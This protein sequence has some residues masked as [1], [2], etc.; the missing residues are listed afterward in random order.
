[1]LGT[2]ISISE[3]ILWTPLLGAL[4]LFL[5]I[6]DEKGAKN[7]AM[8]FSLLS[9][10]ACVGGMY[11]YHQ[12]QHYYDLMSHNAADPHYQDY[13]SKYV[14]YYEI[15]NANWV[16]MPNIGSSFALFMDGMSLL[17]ILLTCISFP[18]IFLSQRNNS[19]SKPV[20]FYALMLLSQTGLIG[21]FLAKDALV[22]YVFWELALIPVYFLASMW[23]GEKRV[24]AAFKFF[25]YTFLGSLLM[26][27]ALI[28][29]YNHPSNSNHTFN[30]DVFRRLTL[31]ATEGKWIFWTMFIAFAIKMPIW[32]FH[33]WQPDAYDQSAT[34]VTMV[35]SGIMVKMGLFAVLRWLIPVA[36]STAEHYSN[37]VIILCLI[38]ILYASLLAM[39]QDNIKKLVAYSSIA[40]IGLMCA[41][42]FVNN[43]TGMYGTIMQMFSHGINIIGL[44]IV[45]DIIEKRTGTKKMS[46]LGGIAHKAP[47][48]SIMLVIIA[49]ANVALPLTNGFVGEFLMFNGLFKQNYWFAAVAG[50]GVILSAIYTLNM[51]AKVFYGSTNSITETFTD[52]SFNQKLALS[53]LIVAIFVFGVF[54]K[55]MFDVAKETVEYFSQRIL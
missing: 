18:V 25:I 42:L 31:S 41:A 9:L 11:Y 5:F 29:L 49:L 3:L 39:V 44:W 20:S 16:W 33:T 54:P 24:R 34:P 12:Y 40:H 1:M 35:L 4:V 46:E 13:Y 15:I 52:I 27:V 55:P 37:I 6:K 8:I 7:I 43:R 21:V 30:L 38:S 47:V 14:S 48:L 23:G 26:L 45:I 51:I 50:L 2:Y 53:I 17:L 19:F 36:Y 32:P 10:I 28:Y 22:F